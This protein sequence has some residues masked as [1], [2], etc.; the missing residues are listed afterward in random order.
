M[1]EDSHMFGF[2]YAQ[3]VGGI[4][5]LILIGIGLLVLRMM[6]ERLQ[7]DA[8]NHSLARWIW[9]PALVVLVYIISQLEQ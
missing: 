5:V 9:P 6:Y 2:S 4:V 7:E 3:I 1:R 8:R